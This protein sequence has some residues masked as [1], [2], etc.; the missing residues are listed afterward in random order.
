MKRLSIGYNLA[1][2]QRTRH[3]VCHGIS[4]ISQLIDRG[5]RERAATERAA[6]PCGVHVAAFDRDVTIDVLA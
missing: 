2:P 1:D 5:H 3:L 6:I 4:L